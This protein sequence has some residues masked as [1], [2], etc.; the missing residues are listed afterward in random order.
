MHWR[1]IILQNENNKKNHLRNSMRQQRLSDLT[2][3]SIE[4]EKLEALDIT[5]IIHK[6]AT[7]KARKQTIV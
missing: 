7:I 6:F 4:Y 1:T 5:D 2:L 3:L